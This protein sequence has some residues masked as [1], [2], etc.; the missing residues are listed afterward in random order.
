[1]KRIIL[2]MAM[3]LLCVP[4]AGISLPALSEGGE[5]LYTI[6]R[7]EGA[8]DWTQIPKFAIVHVQ[9]TEDF[10][11]RAG[12][13][14]CCDSENLYVHLFAVEDE[15]RA[16]YTAP[17]SPVFEDSCLEFFFTGEDCENYFNFEINPNGSLHIQ[18]GPS[19]NNRVSIVKGNDAEYFDIKAQ[20][21]EDGWE[22]AYRIPLEFIRVF[23]PGY[24]F[25]GDLRANAYKCG[26]KTVHRH[27]LTW[28][29]IRSEKPDFH[30][31]EDFGR[32]S[33]E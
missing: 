19:R 25:S 14:L 23:W 11:I 2:I 18:T 26:N 3:A 7:V 16:E 8:V 13:Q 31:P 4:F 29:P 28:N 24:E 22:V 20:R 9:W 17:L 30:R 21:T 10:G 6:S 12:G 27:Y 32:M 33:F 15:I 1:M 5:A